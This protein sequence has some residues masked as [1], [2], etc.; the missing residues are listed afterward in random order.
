MSR[1]TISKITD[2]IVADMA[3]WQNRTARAGLR[4]GADRRDRRQGRDSGVANRPV[5]VAI[6]VDL[7]GERDVGGLWL[8]PTGGEGA[9]QWAAM[10]AELANRGLAD[11][12]VVCCDGLAG[13]PEP[14]RATWPQATVQ[15]CVVHMVPN[16]LRHASKK[17]WGQITKAMREIYTS[18]T[19][20][21]AEARFE[22]FA[23]DW[24]TAHPAMIQ[25]RRKAWDEFVPFGEFPAELR[26]VA[27]TTNAI[28]SHSARFRRAVRHRGHFPNEQAAMKALLPCRHDQTQEPVQ[29]DRQDQRLEDHPEHTGRP[30]RRPDRR[31]HPTNTTTAGYTKNRTVPANAKRRIRTE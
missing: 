8:G 21:A 30:L 26:R 1:D 29:P 15:T 10:P 12:S 18:P 24:E 17:H 27:C 19:A 20:E 31:P 4:G 6:G 11:A 23:D 7:Q 14:I 13:L 2:G 3:V 9:T 28:E 5:H 25:S 22:S 16:S